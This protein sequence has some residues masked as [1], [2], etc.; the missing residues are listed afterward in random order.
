MGVATTSS[1]QNALGGD[2]VTTMLVA[3]SGGHLTQLNLLRPRIVPRDEVLWVTDATAQSESMLA[4]QRVV[5]LPNRAPRA[6]LGILR[7]YLRLCGVFRRER[8]DHVYSTGAQMALS[9][10]LA[11]KTFRVPFSYIESG[12]RVRELSATGRVLA[13]VPGI[14]RYVQYPFAADERW[15][16]ALSVFEGFQ[17]VEASPGAGMP[18]VVV[19]VG[20]NAHYGFERLVRSLHAIIPPDWSV[21]WQVGP[22]DV[23]DLGLS[24]VKSL[25]N[26]QLRAEIA[27]ADLVIS[28]AGTGSILTALQLGKRPIVV[29]RR[30]AHGEHVDGHQDDLAAYVASEGLALVREAD[31]ITL[32]DLLE[33]LQW[34]VTSVG[35]P[36]PVHLA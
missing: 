23:S 14:Q 12:T 19:T 18:R 17:V 6:Y 21:L 15:Q 10:M 20:G 32:A 22:S 34:R 3:T 30:A 31:E 7:D 5:E 13:H 9:A 16:Y 28:H 27:A 11:A 4:G 2:D 26:E 35:D 25:P 24:T 33:S 29:P 1:A 8:I 36:E